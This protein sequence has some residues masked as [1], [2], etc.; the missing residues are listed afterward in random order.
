MISFNRTEIDVDLFEASDVSEAERIVESIAS[1]TFSTAHRHVVNFYV[2]D[3]KD[4]RN[5]RAVANREHGK[6]A[7]SINSWT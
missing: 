2:P 5:P 7:V 6:V 1:R 4:P 3:Q